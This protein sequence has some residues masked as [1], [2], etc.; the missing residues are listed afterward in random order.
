MQ[1]IRSIELQQQE[2][3]EVF[4][5]Q[6]AGLKIY[7]CIDKVHLKVHAIMFHSIFHL[8]AF[9]R[10]Q[11]DERISARLRKRR[12]DL[13]SQEKCERNKKCNIASGCVHRRGCWGNNKK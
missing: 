6:V 3:S 1:S 10:Y 9:Q 11:D 7:S 12:K 13:L 5:F 8:R 4:L 2:M